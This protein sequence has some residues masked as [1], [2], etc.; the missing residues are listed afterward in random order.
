MS[1]TYGHFVRSKLALIFIAGVVVHGGGVDMARDDLVDLI[2]GVH[3]ATE[4]GNLQET[5]DHFESQLHNV[6]LSGDS[7]GELSEGL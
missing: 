7:S 2:E 3:L 4:G 5:K 6:I 1:K